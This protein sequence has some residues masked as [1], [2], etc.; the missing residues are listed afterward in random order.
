MSFHILILA[1]IPNTYSIN[2]YNFYNYLCPNSSLSLNYDYYNRRNEPL[3]DN[4]LYQ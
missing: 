1:Y 3:Y 2:N 4:Y